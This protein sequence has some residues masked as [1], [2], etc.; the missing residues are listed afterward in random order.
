MFFKVWDKQTTRDANKRELKHDLLSS[1][2]SC[3]SAGL[4]ARWPEVGCA[5]PRDLDFN[6]PGSKK[7][8]HSLLLSGDPFRKPETLK[9]DHGDKTLRMCTRTAEEAS[10]CTTS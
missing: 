4:Q 3:G 1:S 6:A 8:S 10:V 7:K 9:R 2:R 5:K